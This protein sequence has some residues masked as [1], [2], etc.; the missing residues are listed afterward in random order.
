M[1]E[2]LIGMIAAL[3]F[4]LVLLYI[5]YRNEKKAKHAH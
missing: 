3:V 1:I 5:D 4:V 2:A